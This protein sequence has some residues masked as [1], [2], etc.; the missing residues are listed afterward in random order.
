MKSVE[1]RN[2]MNET[3]KDVSVDESDPDHKLANPDFSWQNLLHS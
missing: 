3:L 2:V 1:T